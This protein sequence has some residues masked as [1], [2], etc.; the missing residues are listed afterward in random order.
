M[1]GHT[2]VYVFAAQVMTLVRELEKFTSSGQRYP[3]V[4][5][6]DLNSLHDSAVYEFLHRGCVSPGHPELQE[7]AQVHTRIMLW[8][9]YHSHVLT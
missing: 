2:Y 1:Y 7:D 3:L 8:I 6:G 5:T 4:L 9:R